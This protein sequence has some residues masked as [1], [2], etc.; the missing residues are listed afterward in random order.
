MNDLNKGKNKVYENRVI[1]TDED[2]DNI[3][4]CLLKWYLLLVVKVILLIA[5]ILIISKMLTPSILKSIQFVGY[6]LL[7]V[8]VLNLLHAVNEEQ[9]GPEEIIDSYFFEHPLVHLFQLFPGKG[10][11]LAHQ[12]IHRYRCH[13]KR[14]H[15][16]KQQ[17]DANS[18][19]DK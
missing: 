13:K 11:R 6:W 5:L 12:E 3:R 2:Y 1:T 19:S 10:M 9:G 4:G 14:E 16:Q 17:K 18:R 7:M 15:K 8:I